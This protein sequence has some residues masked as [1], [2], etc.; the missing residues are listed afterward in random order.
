MRSTWDDSR[1]H[2]AR[3]YTSS[4]DSPF[5]LE[6]SF[7]QSA[8]LFG[9]PLLLLPCTSIPITLFSSHA[10]TIASSVL[11]PFLKSL[12]L[13]FFLWSSRFWSCPNLV[14]PHT[15]R[16][17]FISAT[18]IFFSCAFFTAH[19]FAPFTIAG[20]TIVLHT[21]PL[22][23]TF[24]FLSHSTPDAFFQFLHP[25]WTLWLTS[26]FIIQWCVL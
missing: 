22:I 4:P 3:S 13:S 15:H 18:S 24:I 20:L 8:H 2:A 10:R 16:N 26:V 11:G 7:T 6:S 5:S 12:P 9:L 25:L 21:F 23:L 1:L 14:T 17:I 19:V